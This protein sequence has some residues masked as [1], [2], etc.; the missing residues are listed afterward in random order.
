[1]LSFFDSWETEEGLPI[2]A[3]ISVAKRGLFF[4]LSCANMKKRLLSAR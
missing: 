3:F 1:M 2:L 4:S